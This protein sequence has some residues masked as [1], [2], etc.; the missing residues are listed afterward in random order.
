MADS[1][2]L[3][4]FPAP[5]AHLLLCGGGGL[6]PAWG[7]LHHVQTHEADV[8]PWDPMI[9]KA[10][11]LPGYLYDD[12]PRIEC[13]TLPLDASPWPARMALVASHLLCRPKPSILAAHIEADEDVI[14][15]Y[16]FAGPM[17]GSRCWYRST[18]M[19]AGRLDD[20]PTLPTHLSAH[21]PEV[22]LLLALYDVPA[23]KARVEALQ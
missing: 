4:A 8:Y 22:A 19:D 7:P 20:L 1:I 15:L 5:L 2:P 23:I 12:G 14:R 10:S 9:G 17:N 21:P 18:G 6:V 11:G 13:W 3:S 16:Y